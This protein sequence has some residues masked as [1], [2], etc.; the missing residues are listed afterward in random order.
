MLT[1][2]LSPVLAIVRSIFLEYNEEVAKHCCTRH[3]DI[4]PSVRYLDIRFVTDFDQKSLRLDPGSRMRLLTCS[5]EKLSDAARAIAA[6]DCRQFTEFAMTR[7]DF[8]ARTI[9]HAERLLK[10]GAHWFNK[11]TFE[12]ETYDLP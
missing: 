2:T 12:K 4:L 10:M 8:L 5:Q 9:V 7:I 3:E 11:F 1:N 6:A